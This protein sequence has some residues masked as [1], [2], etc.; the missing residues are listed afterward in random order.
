MKNTWIKFGCFLTGISYELVANSSE[1]SKKDVKKY[2]SALLILILEWFAVGYFLV[3]NYFTDEDVTMGI[4]GGLVA[5]FIV[6]NVERQIILSR[7]LNWLTKTLRF[8]LALIIALIGA[9][10]I[11]QIIFEEDI[12]IH[13]RENIRE[14]L[15][16]RVDSEMSLL[17][18]ELEAKSKERA[19]LENSVSVM[20]EQ[21][22][23]E[24]NI[25]TSSGKGTQPKKDE[26]GNWILD[27]NGNRKL[28]EF[29]YTR[30]IP[31]P[32]AERLTEVERRI[33]DNQLEIDSLNFK[34][35]GLAINT[36]DQFLNEKGF[37]TEL[38][39]MVEILS[40][41]KLALV[42][43]TLWFLLLVI[44]EMLILTIKASSDESDYSMM[45]EHQEQVRK[46]QIS[47]LK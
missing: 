44:I 9:T 8:C 33:V 32:I 2:M 19:I 23:K 4:F 13:K 18:D 17:Q 25:T 12:E 35:S 31:N 16:K 34:I 41:K 46:A 42:V 29:E 43:Y 21:F 37:L 5:T 3:T 22:A 40:A 36:R 38:G 26:N 7:K 39:Y 6:V 27:E 30:T 24:P 10:V 14:E 1:S 45:V 11:D 28:F 47:S 20:R 15:D